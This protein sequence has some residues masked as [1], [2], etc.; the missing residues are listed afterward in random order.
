MFEH[1]NK[2]NKQL[3]SENKRNLKKSKLKLASWNSLYHPLHELG[4][5]SS[6]NIV[7]T[8]TTPHATRYIIK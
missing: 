2:V 4:A 6:G 7:R 5:T 3:F 1:S 8:T